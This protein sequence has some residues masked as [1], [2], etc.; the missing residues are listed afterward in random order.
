MTASSGS[1][2][3]VSYHTFVIDGMIEFKKRIKG[4]GFL[5]TGMFRKWRDGIRHLYHVNAGWKGSSNGYYLYVQNVN[6]EFEYTGSND[7]MDYRS[8]TAYLILWSKQDK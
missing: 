6:D 8:K 1:L 5:G 3:Y 2:N 4:S 7:A